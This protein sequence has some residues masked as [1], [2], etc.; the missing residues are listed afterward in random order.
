MSQAASKAALGMS[1]FLGIRHDS[2]N[3]Q[4]EAKDDDPYWMKDSFWA[5]HEL[6]TMPTAP[7][8]EEAPP[9]YHADIKHED[10][11]LPPYRP[12]DDEELP[13]YVPPTSPPTNGI[14]PVELGGSYNAPSVSPPATNLRGKHLSCLDIT[15]TNR[16][17]D[18]IRYHEREREGKRKRE[19][20]RK[21][22]FSS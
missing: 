19:R 7:P 20:K 5:D 16:K 11:E 15:D 9:A 8:L 4:P 3:G 1:D 12:P 2:T 14:L 18:T 10:E 13:P 6:S 21:S 22:C 17:F